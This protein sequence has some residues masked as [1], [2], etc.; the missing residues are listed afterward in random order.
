MGTYAKARTRSPWFIDGATPD[1]YHANAMLRSAV[2]RQLEIIGEALNQLTR[3]APEWADA[4]PHCH[5][6]IGLRN[7]LIHGY[8]V[9]DDTIVWR[10]VERDLPRRCAGTST[11]CCA[12]T[13]ATRRSRDRPATTPRISTKACG[14]GKVADRCRRRP[15]DRARPENGQCGRS[16]PFG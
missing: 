1:D 8:A 5:D 13:A 11:R 7:I 4:I 9:I 3:V 14:Q 15:G 2:E 16:A 12:R 10:T 6:A